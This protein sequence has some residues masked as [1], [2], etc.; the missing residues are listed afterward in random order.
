MLNSIF[1]SSILHHAKEFAIPE[2]EKM[3]H[4]RV[5]AMYIIH[6]HIFLITLKQIIDSESFPA[7]QSQLASPRLCTLR[8]SSVSRYHKMFR[9]RCVTVT[10]CTVEN[11]VGDPAEKRAAQSKEYENSLWPRV[12]ELVVGRQKEVALE[13]E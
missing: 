7:S 13:D 3:H 12:V 5:T 8:T 11:E 4:L 2:M 6:H 1:V 9:R 10:A